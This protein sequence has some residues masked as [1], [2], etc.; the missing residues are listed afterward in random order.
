MMIQNKGFVSERAKLVGNEATKSARMLDPCLIT[1]YHNCANLS[2]GQ[3]K[4]IIKLKR[5]FSFR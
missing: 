2:L 1:Y 5:V 4:K 3:S